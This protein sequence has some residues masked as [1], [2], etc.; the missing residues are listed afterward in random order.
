MSYTRVGAVTGANKGVGFAIGIDSELVPQNPQLIDS[1]STTTCP[2]VSEITVQQWTAAHLSYG[3]RQG[4]GGE[5]A[6]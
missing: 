2:P 5:S 4:Q 1:R 6:R 3:E